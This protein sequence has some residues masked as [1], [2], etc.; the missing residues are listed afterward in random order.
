MSH[1]LRELIV[2][3]WISNPEDYQ[4]FLGVGQLLDHEAS[5]FLNDGYFASELGNCMALAAANLLHLPIVQYCA[6]VMQTIIDKYREYRD[7]SAIFN[8]ILP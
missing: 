6:K 3:E 5:L 7:I 8:E 2:H 1:K 4:P